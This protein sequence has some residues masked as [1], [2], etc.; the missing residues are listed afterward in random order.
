MADNA[1]SDW[2]LPVNFYFL[3]EFQSKLERFQTSFTEV[4][5]LN[6]QLST[7]EKPSDLGLW[8][9]MPGG[10]KYGN[11][12]LKRPVPLTS[13][14]TFTQWVDE[15]LQADKNKRMIP[16]DMIVKLLG[17][18]GKPL[19]GWKCSHSYPTQWNLDALNAEKSGLATESVIISCNR[20]DRIKI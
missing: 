6:M 17:K 19:M 11:I 13:D 20:M 8:I 2:T 1:A 15:C 18:D 10:V 7:V 12:T 5:G 9:I 16:Y 3:V 14:D 4:S